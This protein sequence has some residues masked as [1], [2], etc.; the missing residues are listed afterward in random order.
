MPSYSLI[1]D[2]LFRIMVLAC[3]VRLGQ[4]REMS[5]FCIYSSVEHVVLGGLLSIAYNMARGTV[6]DSVDCIDDTELICTDIAV[7]FDRISV[8]CPRKI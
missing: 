3:S 6:R 1:S 5:S 7:H 8:A 4:E 2:G